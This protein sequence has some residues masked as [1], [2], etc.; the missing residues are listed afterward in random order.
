MLSSVGLIIIVKAWEV[1]E[2]R[3]R[4]AKII[5]YENAKYRQ[6]MFGIDF[7]G[8]RE[9]LEALAI[10]TKRNYS[11]DFFTNKSLFRK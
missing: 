6:R 8:D 10:K 4:I 9:R 7:K 5:G 1:R 11:N 2:E 3:V